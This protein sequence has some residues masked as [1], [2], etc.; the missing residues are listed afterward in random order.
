M[1]SRKQWYSLFSMIVLMFAVVRPQPADAWKPYTHN[2]TGDKAYQDVTDNGKVTINGREYAV[3]PAVVAALANHRPF[4]NAGV[5]GPDGFPD[6]TYGQSV[7][8]PEGT[9]DWLR[10]VYNKAW[11]AQGDPSYTATEKSQILAFAYGYL[12]HAAGDMW[13]HTLVN[14][15]AREVFPAVGEILTDLEDAEVALRHIIVEGY[16]GDATGGFD[17]NPARG[18]APFGDVSDDS[19]P[20]VEFDAP[21]RFIYETLVNPAAA[22]PSTERGPIIGFFLDLRAALAA[23]VSDDPDPLGSAIAAYEDTKAALESVEEDCDFDAAEDALYCI[24]ALLAL[25]FDVVIDSAE[26]FAAFVTETLDAALDVVFDSYLAAW[27][28]DI[29]EGLEHWSELGLASTK[30]L[31]DPQTK[32][33]AQND[34]CG[35]EGGEETL[36]RSNCEDAV[37]AVDVLFYASN[38]F[39]LEHLIPML[40]APDATSDVIELLQDFSDALAVM[41]VPF[42]PIEEG[43]AQITEFAKEQ[44]KDFVRESYGIDVDQ[45][46]EF[47]T[48]PTHWLNV[49]SATVTLPGLGPVGLDLFHPDDHARLDAVLG[50]TGDHHEP[51]TVLGV[52]SSRLKDS[53]QFTDDNFAPLKNTVTT[54]KLLLL[55][56]TTLNQVLGDLLVNQ[57]RI[58]AAASVGTYPESVNGFPAN[59]MIDA[60]DQN[61]ADGV[62]PQAWLRSI[63]SDHP[64]RHDGLPRFC[65]DD[66]PGGV[67]PDDKNQVPSPRQA[68]HNG[69]NGQFPLWESCLLRPAFRGIYTDWENGTENFPALGDGVSSDPS[70]QAAPSMTIDVAPKFEANGNTYVPGG[71]QIT[72]GATDAVFT[73]GQLKLQYRIYKDGTAAPTT[74]TE[75]DN[76]TPFSIPTGG[77]DGI[78]H[79]DYRAS[80]PCH[81]FDAVAVQTATFILDTTP[82]VITYTSPGAGQ[83]FDT[84]DFSSIQFSLD[85]GP[86]GS[87]VASHSVTLDGITAVNGQVLDMFFLDPGTHVI[88][89]TASDNLGNTGS[90]SRSFE[91]HATAES[92]VNN[93]DRAWSLGL[94]TD[95]KVYKGLKDKVEQALR[96]HNRG[97]HFVEWEALSAF[98]LQLEGQRGKGIDLVTANRFIAFAQDLIA[99]Q[100]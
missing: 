11:E 33:D 57:G 49:E 88:E 75:I 6:L 96:A 43:L 34:E 69:G 66:G 74:W 12:T 95:A 25:G 17:G 54:A 70:D 9:G 94:I 48:H 46:K 29:D 76:G 36:N 62:T 41:G 89:V 82:P 55:S 31:F 15:F 16:I 79:V 13:A 45:L 68:T 20:G 97:Q 18:P 91:N 42:N 40:G 28:D 5:V 35:L 23:E 60:L 39:M 19:T 4:Y 24:P 7:I 64:W 92:L 61:H 27:I 58:G 86:L 21:H 32:R 26:A 99:L 10:H 3:D 100:R 81:G 71:H 1:S 30:A 65:N 83:V 90:L 67:C 8:H 44:L 85:D 53:A 80:D 56:G 47:L 59:I 22:T 98:I 63:D 51:A 87:G 38:D 37:G 52:Q 78:Y 84:D 73:A 50:L 72:V 14:D 93:V 2:Y 77:G